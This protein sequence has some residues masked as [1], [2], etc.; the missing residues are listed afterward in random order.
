[1]HVYIYGVDCI[2]LYGVPGGDYRPMCAHMSAPP[3]GV[4]V[5]R[6]WRAR[7][8]PRTLRAYLH[9][10]ELNERICK[11]HYKTRHASERVRRRRYD[12]FG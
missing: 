3:S 8:A 7:L 11:E 12:S 10:G 1:M 9:I 5:R 4:R 6:R 2:Q